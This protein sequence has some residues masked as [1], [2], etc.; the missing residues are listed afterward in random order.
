MKRGDSRWPGLSRPGL[1]QLAAQHRVGQ[2]PADA[3]AGLAL[4]AHGAVPRALGRGP[5][6]GRWRVAELAAPRAPAGRAGAP[7]TLRRWRRAWRP[8]R[9]PTSAPPNGG[10]SCRRRRSA[11]GLRWPRLGAS[12]P[13]RCR[14][15][16]SSRPPRRPPGR[17]G[18]SPRARASST[19]KSQLRLTRARALA[20]VAGPWFGPHVGIRT[21]FG[22]SEGLYGV[23]L[24]RGTEALGLH[25]RTP[26]EL[27]A[28]LAAQRVGTAFLEYRDGDEAQR[29]VALDE[30]SERVS[31][32]RLPGCEL[33]LPWDDEVSRAHALLERSAAPGR[34]RT[35][36]RR[37]ARSSTRPGSWARACSATATSCGSGGPRSIFHAAAED[38]LRRT[39]PAIDRAAPA[40]TDS[41]R[42]VL[43]ELCRPALGPAAAPRRTARSPGRCSSAWRP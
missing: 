2:R 6:G 43:V 18:S 26:A 34:S 19:L 1:D 38:E 27:K 10:P 28:V 32:G 17:R 16:R 36:A 39:T 3:R 14:G 40:I 11:G 21:P 31:V 13:S 33:A 22:V 9:A 5:V 12:P 23:E 15:P 35:A 20:G 42:K 8:R 25:R 4:V 7:A 30:E 41:Q 37:T 24:G 29:I